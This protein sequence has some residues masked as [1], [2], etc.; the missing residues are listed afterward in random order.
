MVQSKVH[1]FTKELLDM[2]LVH[3]HVILVEQLCELL[4][5]EGAWAISIELVEEVSDLILLEDFLR[6]IDVF[7]VDFR[8]AEEVLLRVFAVQEGLHLLVVDLSLSSVWVFE[9]A[10]HSVVIVRP[11]C[12]VTSRASENWFRSRSSDKVIVTLRSGRFV[13]RFTGLIL[14]QVENFSWPWP[15]V[16]FLTNAVLLGELNRLVQ[17]F[18]YKLSVLYREGW[19]LRWAWNASDGCCLGQLDFSLFYPA[20]LFKSLCFDHVFF[21]H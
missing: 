6:G 8:W 2:V 15:V 17:F 18:V 4:R 11:Q 7:L 13:I 16:D 9:S 14:C 3:W 21:I 5:V 1:V 20:S 12:V 10:L 19:E